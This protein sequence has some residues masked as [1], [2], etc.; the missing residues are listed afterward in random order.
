MTK[1]Y[2]LLM[3]S[4]EIEG[5]V[6]KRLSSGG[7]YHIKPNPSVLSHDVLIGYLP[8]FFCLCASGKKKK[9]TRGGKTKASALKPLNRTRRLEKSTLVNYTYVWMHQ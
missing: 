6:W 1:C 9:M 2:N 5:E 7:G 3:S 4:G 8:R